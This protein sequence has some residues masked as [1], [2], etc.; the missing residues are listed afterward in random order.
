M[1]VRRSNIGDEACDIQIMSHFAHHR[2]INRLLP[3]GA[4]QRKGVEAIVINLARNSL[5]HLRDQVLRLR[6][7]DLRP[8][9][10]GNLQA[11]IDEAA[12]FLAVQRTKSADRGNTLTELY[13]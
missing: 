6:R 1:A 3:H 2:D 9:I 13:E 7:K 12:S 8:L 10:A 4:R 5:A 11:M